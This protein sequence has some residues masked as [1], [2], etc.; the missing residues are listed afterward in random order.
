VTLDDGTPIPNSASATYSL[1]LPNFVNLGG[2]G[3][4][5]FADG[6]GATQ[7]LDA[8][9]LKEYMAFAGPNFDPSSYPLDRITKLP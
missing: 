8:V 4:T 1:A 7:E 6:Q 5:M 2:D 9:V 3:Y